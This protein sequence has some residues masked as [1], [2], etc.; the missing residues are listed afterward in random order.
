MRF[1]LLGHKYYKEYSYS[2]TLTELSGL[3]YFTFH[4]TFPK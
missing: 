3:L 4:E 1:D 2:P